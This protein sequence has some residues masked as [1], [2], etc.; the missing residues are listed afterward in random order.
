MAAAVEG[1]GQ[2]TVLRVDERETIGAEITE[3][4]RAGRS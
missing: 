2:L 3:P 4:A 1:R